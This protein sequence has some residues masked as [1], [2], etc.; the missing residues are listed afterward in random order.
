MKTYEDGVTDERE[1]IKNEI[2]NIFRNGD[3]DIYNKILDIVEPCYHMHIRVDVDLF[4][5]MTYTCMDCG[6]HV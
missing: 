4:G 6:Y 5:T 3:A 1:R 2:L